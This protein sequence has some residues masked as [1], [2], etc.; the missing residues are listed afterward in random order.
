MIF[1]S[2]TPILAAGN[3]APAVAARGVATGAEG[4]AGTGLDGVGAGAGAC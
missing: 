1:I 4:A 2:I 3:L